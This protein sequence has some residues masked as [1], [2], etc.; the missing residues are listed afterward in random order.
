MVEIRDEGNGMV[1]WDAR[2]PEQ[3]QIDMKSLILTKMVVLPR[4]PFTILKLNRK[5]INS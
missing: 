5:T 3:K 2:S 4:L 1:I